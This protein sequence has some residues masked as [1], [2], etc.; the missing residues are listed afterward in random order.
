MGMTDRQFDTY[1]QSLL[2]DLE[3]I[4]EEMQEIAEGKAKTSRSLEKLKSNIE[5]QLKRP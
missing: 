5:E 2:R 1:Q 3:R 4:E